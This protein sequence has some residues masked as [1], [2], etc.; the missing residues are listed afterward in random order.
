MPL[1]SLDKKI[2]QYL[3]AGT[4]SYE[5]LARRCNVTRNTIYRRISA[6][7]KQ[8]V[9]KNTCNCIVNFNLLDISAITVGAKIA[10]INQEK[11]IHRLASNENVKWLWRAYGVH[12]VALVAF[13]AKG[14][15]GGTIQGITAILEDLGAEN[16][17][18][19]VGFG[20]EKMSNTPFAE[21]T[22]VELEMEM[23]EFIET[24]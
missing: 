9:I 16:L 20:W 5:E 6:L 1:D 24:Y 21:H 11:A 10:A 3:S 15:E 19:S 22:E 4:S 8:G 18:V 23:A 12:N 17:S 7:E 13:C 14:K 2:I